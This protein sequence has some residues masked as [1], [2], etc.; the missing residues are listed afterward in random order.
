MLTLL[1]PDQA[2]LVVTRMPR[3]FCAANYIYSQGDKVLPQLTGE[4]AGLAVAGVT[5][6]LLILLVS[7]IAALLMGGSVALVM[8][9]L[10]GEMWIF[11]LRFNQVSVVNLIMATGGS[12]PVSAVAP[13]AVVK[14]C[15]HVA[16]LH[17]VNICIFFVHRTGC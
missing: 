2:K 4:Y 11:S 13:L 12:S 3:C 5:V 9:Y 14:A 15:D 16:C 7:P 1:Q 6:V 10:F 17:G 8:L